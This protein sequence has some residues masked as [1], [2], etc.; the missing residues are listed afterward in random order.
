MVGKLPFALGNAELRNV[1]QPTPLRNMV[2]WHT[3]LS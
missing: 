3:W 1:D 2:G